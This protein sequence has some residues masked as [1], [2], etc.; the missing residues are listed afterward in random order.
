MEIF[1][2]RI[3][4]LQSSLPLSNKRIKCT[5]YKEEK[6]MPKGKEALVKGEIN[7]VQLLVVWKLL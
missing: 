7:V 1:K 2:G 6:L 4:E 5:K 3:W